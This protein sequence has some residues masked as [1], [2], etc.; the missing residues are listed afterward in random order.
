MH[1]VGQNVEKVAL[2]SAR[3]KMVTKTNAP[4]KAME[5]HIKAYV[6]ALRVKREVS[7]STTLA[8]ENDLHHFCDYLHN[9]LGRAPRLE[10]FTSMQVAHFLEA[11]HLAGRRRNTLMRR[12]ATLRGFAAYLVQQGNKKT[13]ILV[14][15]NQL[16]NMVIAGAPVSEQRQ[17]LMAGEIERLWK[18]LD[19]S[20]RPRARRDRAILALLLDTGISVKRLVD[21]N[22]DELEMR[23]GAWWVCVNCSQKLWLMLNDPHHSISR[24]LFEGRPELN[25][26][27]G[28]TA[29]FISQTGNRMNRQAVWQVLHYWGKVIDLPVTLSPRV[30]RN[31]AIRQLRHS[32][33]PAIELSW[34]LGHKNPISTQALFRR[35]NPDFETR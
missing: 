12:K 4:S 16:I 10:D 19:H 8:Y 6:E 1:R 13:N 14:A 30:V 20:A 22:L 18:V 9:I 31:T 32:G 11:E 25:P 2:L 15:D 26:Q 7:R 27:P 33:K 17:Y 35:L 34:V 29:L 5:T 24:Y 3:G 21:L 23:A 28:D